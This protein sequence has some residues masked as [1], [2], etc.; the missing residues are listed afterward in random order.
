MK[1]EDFIEMTAKVAHEANRAYCQTI[2][3][4]SQPSWED[5]PD[6]QK[7]SA[8]NG[9]AFRLDHPHTPHYMSH[10][11]W[12]K[13]KEA[14]GWTYGPVKDPE[15]KQHPC[16]LPY[17]KLPDE[18]KQKDALFCNIVFAMQWYFTVE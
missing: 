2:G 13:H 14:E 6:W 3:D 10:D 9:V 8:R 11:N 4:Y 1:R 12:L 18:D 16:M 7:D 5:A 17:G 15:K